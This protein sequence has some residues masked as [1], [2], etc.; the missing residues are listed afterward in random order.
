MYSGSSSSDSGSSSIKE[1][2]SSLNQPGVEVHCLYGY[3]G[4]PWGLALGTT[5]L[6]P[7]LKISNQPVVYP[8]VYFL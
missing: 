1:E 6:R 2:G 4:D 3:C 5:Q 7:H 8:S